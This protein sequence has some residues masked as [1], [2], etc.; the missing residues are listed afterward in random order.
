M[1]LILTKR[2]E[3]RKGIEERALTF[4][5]LTRAPICAGYETYYASGFYKFRELM[6]DLPDASNPDVE[7]IL[8]INVNGQVL[9]D[10]RELDEARPPAAPSRAQRWVQEPERLEAVKRL[11]HTAAARAATPTARRRWRSS[12]PTSRT[13]AATSCR[14]PTR[15]PTGT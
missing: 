4:A 8:I 9:F 13:G 6:R 10:S 7:R 14:S 3:L 11:E 2:A 15:S 5:L 1:Y 12:P